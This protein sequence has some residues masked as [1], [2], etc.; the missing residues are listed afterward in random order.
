M[1]DSFGVDSE[2][3]ICKKAGEAMK[4]QIKSQGVKIATEQLK[5]SGQGREQHSSTTT[6][7][8]NSIKGEL[9]T[10]EM[11]KLSESDKQ[12]SS[13]REVTAKNCTSSALHRK[14]GSDGPAKIIIPNTKCGECRSRHV[15]SMC[16]YVQKD[17]KRDELEQNSECETSTHQHTQVATSTGSR[18]EAP[19]VAATTL[20]IVGNTDLSGTLLST[21]VSIV[22]LEE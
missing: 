9:E 22:T 5:Y 1:T 12:F 4:P 13:K 19:N 11:A 10:L 16:E 2:I 7:L 20:N 3:C 6:F 21:A 15:T 8:L 18:N 14:D 17:E